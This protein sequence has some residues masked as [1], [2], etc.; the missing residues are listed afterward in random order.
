MQTTAHSSNA[1]KRKATDPPQFIPLHLEA[2]THVETAV[3]GRHLHLK[4][5]TMRIN[6]CK[7][8]GEIRPIKVPGS[9]KLLWPVSEIRRV[10]GVA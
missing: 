8:L 4:P 3:A 7:Q 6:A 1:T 10:L 9:A 2:R 5:Q